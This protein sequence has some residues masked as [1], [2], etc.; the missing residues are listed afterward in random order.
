[1]NTPTLNLFASFPHAVL[2][3]V[4]VAAV[5]A[6]LG[7]FVILKRVV[8]IG[9]TL[10]ETAACGV[11]VALMLNAPPFA[12]A[13]LL[14]LLTVGLLAVPFEN[15]R[16]PRD[17]VLGVLF[18]AASSLGVLLVAHSGFGLQEVK[19]LLYGDLILATT[20]DLYVIGGVLIPAAVCLLLFIRPILYAF[21]DRE[22]ATVLGVRPARWE[23][24]FFLLLGLVVAAASKAAG[25]LMVFCHL[26]APAAAALL[27]VRR[28][29]P[30][31]ILAVALA[32]ASTLSGLWL[33]FRCDWPTNQTV[34]LVACA[35]LPVTG[36]ALGVRRLFRRHA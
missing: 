28:L 14:T 6:L 26:I 25:A 1:V 27:L 10:A 22:A 17:A 34:C 5:C 31:L 21:V 29:W 13:L 11:A 33:S 19:A 36:L 2:A 8:F 9:I 24:L 18:V 32:V 15:R 12:G 4:L 7:V 30:V 16:I 23:L 20:D 35:L 3:G